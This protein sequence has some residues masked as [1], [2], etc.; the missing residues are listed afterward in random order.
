MKPLET[1]LTSQLILLCSTGCQYD[2]SIVGQI[3]YDTGKEQTI[4]VQHDTQEPHDTSDTESPQETGETGSAFEY[5][6]W[7]DSF[8]QQGETTGTD[9]IWVIDK[10]GS[11][12]DDETRVLAGIEAMMNALPA[13]GWRLNMITTDVAGVLQDQLFPLVPGD[14]AYNAQEM[15]RSI[16]GTS[17]TEAGLEALM[18]YVNNNPYAQT[19]MRDDA[20]FLAVF[21]SDEEDQ[22]FYGYSDNDAIARFETEFNAFRQY[23]YV[24]S[25]VHFPPDTSLCNTVDINTGDRYLTVAQD[26]GGVPIDICSEEWSAGV[27]DASEQVMPYDSWPLKY[28]PLIDSLRVFEDGSPVPAYDPNTNIGDWQYD[29]G[30]NKVQFLVVPPANIFVEIIYDIDLT[31]VEDCPS[32]PVDTGLDT[33]QRD[34]G[35]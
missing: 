17:G 34:T 7:T 12:S 14:T 19:W 32:T 29:Q 24:A 8:R 27:Q 33:G 21:V 16:S 4:I 22:S 28:Q 10:S 5:C 23:K 13:T 35:T 6:L 18:N 3:V 11:M 31:T 9:I 1:V 25:I 20:L 15:Y 26:Y 30:T 2:Y